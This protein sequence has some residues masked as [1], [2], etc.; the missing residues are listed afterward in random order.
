MKTINIA[1]RAANTLPLEKL[2]VIQGDLKSLSD[3]N[4]QKLKNSILKYGFSAP[5]FVWESGIKRPKY[6][7]LDGTQRTL[8]LKMLQ[9]EGYKIPQLPVVYIQAKNKKEAMEKLLHITSQYGEFERE[10]LDLFL[11]GI[12]AD[13]ELLET[14]RL[15]NDEM[16][17]NIPEFVPGTEEEQ[18]QLDKLDPK[19]ITCPHCGKEFDVQKA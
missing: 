5:I 1:C 18:G 16:Y 7:I 8:V 6:N 13:E 3:S 11:L 12:N 17:L 15:S 14:L 10:G 9:E 4:S 2:T 19:I